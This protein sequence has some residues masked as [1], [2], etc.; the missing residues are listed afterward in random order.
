MSQT[1]LRSL[2]AGAVLAVAAVA[3]CVAASLTRADPASSAAP[4]TPAPATAAAPTAAPT[5]AVDETLQTEAAL[6]AIDDHWGRAE[7]DGDVAYLAQLLAPE[8]RSIGARGEATPRAALLD[9]TRRRTA[10][11]EARA[12]ARKAVEAFKQTHPTEVAVVLHGTLGIVSFFNPKRGA[13][14]SVRG[15]DIFVYEGGR[16]HAVYSLHNAAD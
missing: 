11:A 9:H 14:H 10:S 4:P 16:W 3:L 2:G 1:R 7:G 5:A 6:R 8:Y 15:A 12:E 13:D